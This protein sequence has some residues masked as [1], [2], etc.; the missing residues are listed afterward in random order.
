MKVVSPLHNIHK[1]GLYGNFE[2]KNE[3]DLIKI[4]E[5]KNASIY[6][7]VKYNKSNINI[8]EIKFDNL[9]FPKNLKVTSN[10]ETR[11]LWIGPNNWLAISTKKN[12]NNSFENFDEKDFAITDLSHSRSIIELVGKST[13]E[14]IKKGCPINLTN[15]KLNSC[16]NSVFNGITI[17]LDFLN[18]DP[19][20]IRIMTLRSFGESLYN[21]LTDSCLEYGYKA[22]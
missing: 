2:N 13:Y 12:L 10:N 16:S 5:I 1:E 18:D 19:K 4:K 9:E 14:V 11:I 8:S 6:Q 3:N 21:S 17:T 20:K 15:I 7:I 22:I